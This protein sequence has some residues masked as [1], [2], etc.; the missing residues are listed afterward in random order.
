MRRLRVALHAYPRRVR[1]AEGDVLLD[2]AQDLADGP[3]SV[4]REAAGL[5]RGGLV[6]RA[7]ALARAPWDGAL[8]RLAVPLAVAFTALVWGRAAQALSST[9]PDWPGWSWIVTLLA[10]LLTLAGLLAGRRTLAAAGALLLVV[11]GVAQGNSRPVTTANWFSGI[12]EWDVQGGFT[13]GYGVAALG[14]AIPGGLVL[15][16]AAARLPHAPGRWRW[17]VATA[18]AAAASL[19]VFLVGGQQVTLAGLHLDGVTLSLLAYGAAVAGFAAVVAGR[20]GVRAPAASLAAL[21]AL[22]TTAPVL[23]LYGLSALPVPDGAMVMLLGLAA[24]A[25]PAAFVRAAASTARR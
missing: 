25:G 13:H 11:L 17:S 16:A 3:S 6:V 7:G 10:P 23:A 21:L 24:I 15:L 22:A 12:F 18:W 14:C 8:E 9:F 1:K 19:G 20:R 4:N 5:V 2:L